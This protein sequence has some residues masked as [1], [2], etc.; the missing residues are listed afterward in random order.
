MDSVTPNEVNALIYKTRLHDDGAFCELVRLYTPMINKVVLGF[1]GPVVR[2]D[3]A[4]SE[5]CV[6]LHSAAMSYDSE[7]SGVTFGLYARICVYRRILDFSVKAKKESLV[8]G[9]D[10]N[11]LY[12]ESSVESK[13]LGKERIREYLKKARAVLSEYEYRVFLL[14]IEGYS[15][16]EIAEKLKRD[17]KSVENAKTR[18]FKH[19]R[20]ESDRFSDI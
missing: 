19:L 4:F 16:Q 12:T 18:M 10:V 3:E 7:R 11:S 2:Y 20:E 13:I 1:T 17:T 8:S 9:V 6:A 5:A 15:T 14:Y